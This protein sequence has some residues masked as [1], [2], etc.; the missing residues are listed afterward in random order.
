MAHHPKSK[1]RP[2]KR[3][4]LVTVATLAGAALVPACGG[5]V[6]TDGSGN[7]GGSAGSD[8]GSTTTSAGGATG[9]T[10]GV[11]T[12]T[13]TGTTTGVGG[14]GAGGST[15][16]MCPTSMPAI[17]SSCATAGLTCGYPYC[18][19]Q[20]EYL[21]CDGSKW[22]P[23][24]PIGTCNPPPPQPCPAMEPIVET[25]C[26]NFTLQQCSYADVCCNVW[27]GT[28]DY[29]CNGSTWQRV[30]GDAGNH[31]DS[32]ACGPCLVD[33]T[34]YRDGDP[35]AWGEAGPAVVEASLTERG[36]GRD[37]GGD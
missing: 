35:F 10:T 1:R 11:T 29:R 8:P 3:P 13:T 28:R 36:A 6:S 24:G 7:A 15:N 19:A 22:T 30:L 20:V 37:G 25:S 12:S 31:V 27:R 9:V 16:A 21:R 2:L 23:T 26:V 17:G 33:D 4:F 5:A 14:N 18:G 32:E 34:A